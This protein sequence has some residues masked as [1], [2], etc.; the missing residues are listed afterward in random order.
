MHDQAEAL[1]NLI[2]NNEKLAA[3]KKTRIITVTSG[4][5][6]WANQTLV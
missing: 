6:A 4:K 3:G 1:R 2:R 5:G